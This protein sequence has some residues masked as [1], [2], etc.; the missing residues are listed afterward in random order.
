MVEYLYHVDKK[1]KVI[2]KIER[3]EAH[4]LKL[5][6]R[7]GVVLVF[8]SEKR[9]CLT[10]RSPLKTI[11]PNCV[12]SACSFHVKFGQTYLEAAEEE[13]FEETKIKA[14]PKYL[15]KSLLDRGP[16][17]MIMAIFRID[18]DE[19]ILLDPTEA[20]SYKFYNSDEA[21]KLIKTEKTT[22]WLPM[23][24]KLTKIKRQR[25]KLT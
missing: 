24:W 13:L 14:K 9:V 19:K 16:D 1:D 8:D 25:P 11:F 15:G 5:L 10:N 23:A 21:D 2:A 4:A 20:T 18:T 3:N 12:D 22:S 6:H 7:G 17:R